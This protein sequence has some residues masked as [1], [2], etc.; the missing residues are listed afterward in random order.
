MGFPAFHRCFL[1]HPVRHHAVPDG[2]HGEDH[3]RK[4]PEPQRVHRHRRGAL[5]MS[6]RD[7]G[8]VGRPA[9][10]GGLRRPPAVVRRG[11]RGPHR[12]ALRAQDPQGPGGGQGRPLPEVSSAL[13]LIAGIAALGLLGQNILSNDGADVH[14][15]SFPRG[16]PERL[17]RRAV[18]SL[19]ELATADRAARPGHRV[20][21]GH[22]GQRD[23]GGLLLHREAD[24]AGFQPHRR[25]GS[26]G[27][28]SA[29]SPPPRPC[30]TSPSRC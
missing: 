19:H 23:P 14:V 20:R 17:Q 21:G 1:Y 8:A 9:A 13:V 15:F 26:A 25:P 12:G 10:S 2:G 3:R 29:P 24:H 27:G 16:Q 7:P 30:S 28:C 22:P 18:S 5:T 6:G 4:L 11:G